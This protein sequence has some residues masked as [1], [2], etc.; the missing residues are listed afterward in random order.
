MAD[1]PDGVIGSDV[2]EVDG[3][4]PAAGQECVW[5]ARMKDAS[6]HAIVMSVD[7][8]ETAATKCVTQFARYMAY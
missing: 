3:V 7:T 1:R 6:K 4:V 2:P 8:I 5:V